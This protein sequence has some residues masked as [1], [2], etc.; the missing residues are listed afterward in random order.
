MPSDA[1]GWYAHIA[2]AIEQ[3][4]EELREMAVARATPEEFGLKVRAHPETLL[5][6][7][8][9][10][11]GSSEKVVVQ[12][13]L[14]A[15]LIET[16]TLRADD[17]ARTHN[18]GLAKRLVERILRLGLSYEQRGDTGST[19]LYQGVPVELVKEFVSGFLN[20]PVSML[21]DPGPVGNY[22]DERAASELQYWDV[23]I[24]GLA[25]ATESQDTTL[26]IPI[27]LQNRTSGRSDR[28]TLRLSD[29]R[30][31]ASVGTEKFGL[32]DAEISI[33][34]EAFW[35]KQAE[36]NRNPNAVSGLAPI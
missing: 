29:N 15:Q 9:N 36:L 16:A 24:I 2:E 19:R 8:R 20:H 7:A 26:G 1:I 33:A 10:K 13:G 17:S 30:R 5:V 23:A 35:K 14:S 25:K 18:L 6:T 11:M 27:N 12:I 34:E 21:T 4:R 3:L 28:S 32:S 22:I 31:V